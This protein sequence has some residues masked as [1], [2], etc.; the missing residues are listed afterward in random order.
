MHTQAIR[1]PDR[2]PWVVL[3]TE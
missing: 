1:H 2:S 3:V